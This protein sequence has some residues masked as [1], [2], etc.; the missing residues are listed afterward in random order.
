MLGAI[1][2]DIIG[3]VHEHA[4]TKT[5]DFP[6]FTQRSAFTDDTVLTVAIAKSILDGA[7]YRNTVHEM[8]RKY[9]YAGYGKLFREWMHARNPKPYNSCGNGSAMR[10]SPVGFA[11]NSIEAV[12][13]EARKSAQITHNHP[14]G[15]KGAQA[16]A[17][18]IYY[19]RNGYHKEH[20]RSEIAARFGYNLTRSIDDIR[21]YYRFNATCQE[22]VPEAIIAFL[23]SENFEDAIRLAISLGGDADTLACI[24]GGI[25]EAYYGILPRPIHR[26]VMTNLDNE[27]EQIVNRFYEEYVNDCFSVK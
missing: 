6:L 10:V 20:I 12:L 25:A 11:C 3:S 19:A 7:S 17:L 13:V 5:K 8:A 2:G 21:P 24:T 23:E 16:T 4:A 26:E 15:I 22:T 27:L 9:P 1:A 14:E 18:A